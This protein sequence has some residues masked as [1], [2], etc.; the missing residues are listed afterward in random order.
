[1]ESNQVQVVLG[2]A[3]SLT[4][5]LAEKTKSSLQPSQNITQTIAVLKQ[6]ATP[7]GLT[8]LNPSTATDQNAYAVTRATATAYGLKTLSD[9]AAKCPGGVT[10]GGPANCPQRPQCQPGLE[11]LYGLKIT[12][13]TALDNDGPL[14]RT[15]LKTG[16][17][18]LGVVFSS[19]PDASPA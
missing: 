2:Y 14:T 16:K 10:L 13:F 15:A 1:L 7:R 4:T 18:L 5:Y 3:A 19:D 9:L 11:Q 17:V 8:I 12:G 6:L